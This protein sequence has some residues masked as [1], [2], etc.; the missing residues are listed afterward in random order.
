MGLKE[1]ELK[2]DGVLEVYYSINVN[3]WNQGFTT[4]ALK[5]IIDFGFNDIG[6]ELV[7]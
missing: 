7:R 6:S 3:Y 2:E 1:G 5:R 4:E